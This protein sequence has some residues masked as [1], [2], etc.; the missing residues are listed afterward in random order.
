VGTILVTWQ[1]HW[2]SSRPVRPDEHTA[3]VT[4][5][6]ADDP[7]EVHRSG[8]DAVAMVCGSRPCEMPT[9]LT[10]HSVEM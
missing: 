6:V 3:W 1:V 9:R 5:A 4:L 8:L 10:L 2:T 7:R